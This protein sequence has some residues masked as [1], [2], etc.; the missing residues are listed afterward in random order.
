MAHNK[1]KKREGGPMHVA[2][3]N[4]GPDG[5]QLRWPDGGSGRSGENRGVGW[6]TWAAHGECGPAREEAKW[7]GPERIQCRFLS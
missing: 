4:T 6:H 5:W 3:R 7:A 2:Q 1:E